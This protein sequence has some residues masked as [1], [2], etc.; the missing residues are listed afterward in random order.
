MRRFYNERPYCEQCQVESVLDTSR[1]PAK[2]GFGAD[3]KVRMPYVCPEHGE[4]YLAE[5]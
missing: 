3:L 2:I 5:W 1:R 4:K